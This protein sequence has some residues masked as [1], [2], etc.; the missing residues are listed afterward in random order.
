MRKPKRRWLLNKNSRK[1]HDLYNLDER[2]N[3][4]DIAQGNRVALN[5]LGEAKH[6]VSF[7]GWCYERKTR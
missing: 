6:G 3:V 2:C 4:D 1:V 7:C 5:D